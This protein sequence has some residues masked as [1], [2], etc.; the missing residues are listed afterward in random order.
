MRGGAA[1][2]G[3]GGEG[4]S[5][6]R[7]WTPLYVL[8]RLP[9]RNPRPPMGRRLGALLCL[10]ATVWQV[11]G[12]GRS[13]VAFSSV[14]RCGHPAIAAPDV[15]GRRGQ[16]GSRAGLRGGLRLLRAAAG[17]GER[18]QAGGLPGQDSTPL[19]S[20]LAD[21]ASKVGVPFFF[22]GHQMG[23][24]TPLAFMD[25]ALPRDLPEDVGC[26]SRNRDGR[27][28]VEADPSHYLSPSRRNVLKLAALALAVQLRAFAPQRA[29]A[30]A[31]A[32]ARQEPI[33]LGRDGVCG[34]DAMP[35]T[36]QKV[37]GAGSYKTVYLVT[38]PSCAG[39]WAL[40][41]ERLKN[42]D[43]AAEELRGIALAQSLQETARVDERPR[44]ERIDSW[45]LQTEGVLDFAPGGEVMDVEYPPARFTTLP[46]LGRPLWLIAMKPVYD[47]DLETFRR[48]LP[49]PF[50]AAQTAALAKTGLELNDTGAICLALDLCTA[51]R[52]LHDENIIH[53]DIK[54]KNV[55]LLD[56]RAVLIDFGYAQRAAAERG[57]GACVRG[58]QGELPYLLAEDV[59][60]LRGCK[61]GDQ[62]AMGKTIFE[63][64]FDSPAPQPPVDARRT[65][66]ARNYIT[67]PAAQRLNDEFRQRLASPEAGVLARFDLSPPVA[68]VLLRV[69]RGLCAAVNPSSFRTAELTLV[70][71]QRSL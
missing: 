19:L 8:E 40:A 33:A 24:G 4:R 59:R 25:E 14:L 7:D 44:F 52:V 9:N 68:A 35:L 42:R 28:S 10:A 12:A 32:A 54:P 49:V 63:T 57:A 5:L 47:M 6:A 15:R 60:S 66:K 70:E 71:A 13:V 46:R 11:A 27:A 53:R 26:A 64:I 55:M 56:G 39:R 23:P 48:S 43:M 41:V 3:K 65:Q 34:S 31:A 21:A 29:A 37:L 2:K 30:A 20:A 67:A 16:G 51:G 61:E 69:V 58:A 50:P 1:C 36:Y 38:S 22:N 18:G 17:A 45:W 62:Y